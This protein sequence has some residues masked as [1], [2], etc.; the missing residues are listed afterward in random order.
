MVME[1]FDKDRF[2]ELRANAQADIAN[3]ANHVGLLGQKADL[4]LLAK[5]HFPEAVLDFGR[6]RKLLDAHVRA[7]ANVTQRANKRLRTFRIGRDHQGA[8]VHRDGN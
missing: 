6:G 3:L 8:I 2:G 4:L 1:R 7:C 5:T